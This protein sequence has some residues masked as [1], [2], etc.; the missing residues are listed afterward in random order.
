VQ[1]TIQL[2]VVHMSD[3]DDNDKRDSDQDEMKDRDDDAEKGRDKDRNR[4]DER[5][6]RYLR[7]AKRLAAAAIQSGLIDSECAECIV[8]Q[9][10]AHTPISE[11]YACGP[12]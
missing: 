2:A 6:R 3:S 10:N 4:D 1:K 9:F 5:S 8:S 11:Q 7:R 12:D